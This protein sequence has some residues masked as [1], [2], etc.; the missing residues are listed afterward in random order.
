MGTR[1]WGSE[2]IASGGYTIW[3]NF[4]LKKTHQQAHFFAQYLHFCAFL[5]LCFGLVLPQLFGPV[6]FAKICG[7]L[8]RNS[9][10]SALFDFPIWVQQGG[11][12][13]GNR[14]PRPGGYIIWGVTFHF[15]EKCTTNS[16]KPLSGRDSP[17]CPP[18]P[19]PQGGIW[20]GSTGSSHQHR[21][22]MA[23]RTARQ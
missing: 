2:V 20:L 12:L 5:T 8:D 19:P 11:I 23:G 18:R 21:I 3:G 13:L 1:S 22:K 4:K 15:H 16:E 6:I 14:N 9:A 17:A 10:F 7:F